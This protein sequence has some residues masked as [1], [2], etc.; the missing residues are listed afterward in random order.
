MGVSRQL[1]RALPNFRLARNPLAMRRQGL[2]ES[3]SGTRWMPFLGT[4][5]R[6]DFMWTRSKV[7]SQDFSTTV[8]TL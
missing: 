6:A 2:S 3:T 7:S 1:D 8:A 5:R 4:V